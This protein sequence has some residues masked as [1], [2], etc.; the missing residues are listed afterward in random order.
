MQIAELVALRLQLTN[1][2][3]QV[4]LEFHLFPDGPIRSSVTFFSV[5]WLQ[6]R[7]ANRVR[8]NFQVRFVDVYEYNNKKMSI[9]YLHTFMKDLN[10]Y[11]KSF[12]LRYRLLIFINNFAQLQTRSGKW[13]TS[14]NRKWKILLLFNGK[15]C[16]SCKLMLG[17]GQYKRKET[18][19]LW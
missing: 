7:D 8:D 4:A 2:L 9:A 10:S 16:L 1:N 5:T 18:V 13:P 14:S 19:Q 15:K 6:V 17:K 3:V 11:F 12:Y